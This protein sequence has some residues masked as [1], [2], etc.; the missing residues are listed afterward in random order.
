MSLAS[1]AAA[2][3]MVPHH[4]ALRQEVV[5]P[6]RVVATGRVAEGPS[7]LLGEDMWEVFALD[8]LP[9]TEEARL[10]HA[11][12]VV[13][14]SQDAL[15]SPLESVCR[16]D[17]VVVSGE[18]VIERVDGPIEDDLSAVPMWIKALSVASAV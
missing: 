4:P 8:P 1:L 11:C 17:R 7:H 12:E 14:R 15:K 5:M 10:A 18:L 9:D 3:R 6:I 13:C 2:G 16:G